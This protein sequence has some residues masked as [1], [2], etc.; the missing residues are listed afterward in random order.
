M[1]PSAHSQ[2]HIPER[3]LTGQPAQVG[4]SYP[5][6]GRLGMLLE[7]RGKVYV[8]HVSLL[9]PAWQQQERSWCIQSTAT[10][11]HCHGIC[12]Q[13]VLS[14]KS[15][16]SQ[17]SPPCSKSG[18]LGQRCPVPLSPWHCQGGGHVLAQAPAMARWIPCRNG[19]FPAQT[20]PCAHHCSPASPLPAT[21]SPDVSFKGEQQSFV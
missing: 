7:C 8:P 13:G 4:Y 19:V 12:L 5:A 15:L 20:S 2:R 16:G 9:L 10:P 3:A 17:I 21:L 1:S 18:I 6:P 11:E 14:W